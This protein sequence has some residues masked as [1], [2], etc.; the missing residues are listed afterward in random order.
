V[1]RDTSWR[2]ENL[3]QVQ[4][5]LTHL[6]YWSALSTSWRRIAQ[7]HGPITPA[8]DGW[9][10]P[11]TPSLS[12][13]AKIFV[14]RCDTWSFCYFGKRWHRLCSVLLTG[15]D[16]MPDIDHGQLSRWLG[17]KSITTTVDLYGHLVPEA[18][19]SARDALDR[20]FDSVDVPGICPRG[21]SFCPC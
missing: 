5:P 18:S 20:A 9:R 12:T 14:E 4:V 1:F 6:D 21:R 16:L 11:R 13:A 2:A 19:G 3:V 17:D 8:L 10:C 7:R 15:A